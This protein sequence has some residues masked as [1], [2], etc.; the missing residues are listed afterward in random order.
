MHSEELDLNTT[1][2]IEFSN[3]E[4]LWIKPYRKF[5]FFTSPFSEFIPGATTQIAEPNYFV[6]DQHHIDDWNL[7]TNNVQ[8]NWEQKKEARILF[9]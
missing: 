4:T 1:F 7:R 5:H 2:D 3:L 9:I 8:H 6:L